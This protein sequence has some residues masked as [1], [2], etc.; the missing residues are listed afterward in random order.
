MHHECENR[1][2]GNHTPVSNIKLP[3]YTRRIWY[4]DKADLVAIMNSIEMFRWKEHLD[5]LTCPN[6]QVELLNEVLLNIFTNVI[7]NKVKTIRPH[8][9]PWLTEKVKN[10]LRKKNRAYRNFMRNSQPSD[11]QEGIQRMISEGSK[12]IEDAKRKNKQL[13]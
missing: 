13:N 7:P 9:A 12:L 1:L 3:P 4:Y 10:F 8:Q 11:K 5:N 6:E 2:K